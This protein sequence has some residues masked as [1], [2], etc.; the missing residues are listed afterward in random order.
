MPE[1]K[2][3][4]PLPKTGMKGSLHM[5]WKRC[6]KPTCR[7][8]TGVLHGPYIYRRWRDDAGRQKREYIP[9]SDVLSVL[10][11]L[12]AR[13]QVKRE[14]KRLQQSLR[15]HGKDASCREP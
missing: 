3:R 2:M 15:Q 13:R 4:D 9:S 10:L 14:I 1:E 11:T 5:E 12:E 6:G 8:R 7:C